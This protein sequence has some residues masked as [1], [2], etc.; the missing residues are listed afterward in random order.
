MVVHRKHADSGGAFR[1]QVYAPYIFINKTGCEF[2]LKT[3]TILTSAKGVAGQEVAVGESPPL[4]LNLR[5]YAD[6][7]EQEV[8]SD[9]VPS[10]SCSHSR[11]M[12]VVTVSS[13][14][15]TT[16]DGQR[17]VPVRS[18]PV[19]PLLTF[20]FPQ[21]LSFETVGMET[22]VVMPSATGNEEIHVGLK[23]TEGLGD[24]SCAI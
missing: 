19:V 14:G 9:A 13:S 17:S 15:S 8:K 16:R 10:H 20:P 18:L 3:K 1:V 23:V 12:T 11:L 21:P 24:V 22:E 6:A 7:C 2:A 5:I 4:C